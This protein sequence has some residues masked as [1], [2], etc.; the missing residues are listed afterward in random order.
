MNVASTT[1]AIRDIDRAEAQLADEVG[2]GAELVGGEEI[3]L[4]AAAGR[5]LDAIDGFLR[6]FVDG[7]RGILAG[8]EFQP[9]FGGAGADE[10]MLEKGNAVAAATKL[11]R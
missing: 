2:V 9:E 8:G 1:P 11:R 10:T 5:R 6:A 4:Y 7:M 3:D